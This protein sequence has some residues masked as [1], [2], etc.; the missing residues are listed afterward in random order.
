M[1]S[2][3]DFVCSS[4]PTTRTRTVHNGTKLCAAPVDVYSLRPSSLEHVTFTSYFRD[5]RLVA[6]KKPRSRQQGALP[7]A[8]PM[9]VAAAA[10]GAVGGGLAAAAA[11]TTAAATATASA[12][13]VGLAAAPVL[14]AAT[15]AAAAG[16]AVAGAAAWAATAVQHHE[17][18]GPVMRQAPPGADLVGETMDKHHHVYKLCEPRIVRFS[19]YNPAADPEGYFYTLLLRHVPFRKE[20]ELLSAANTSQTYFQECR[21]RGL[22]A[23]TSDLEVHLQR[24]GPVVQ[25]ARSSGH[26]PTVS[27]N[28]AGACTAAR[29]ALHPGPEARET[30][31]S[32]RAR[33]SCLHSSSATPLHLLI[34]WCCIWA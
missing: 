5:Y 16:A 26:M 32:S 30:P 13:A 12:A 10:V 18:D 19:D 22:V 17:Q 29:F 15:A 31:R 4:P 28:E 3:V 21:L 34:P 20:G 23:N 1:S 6:R 33:P 24:Y 2:G 11:T 25:H 7:Q 8:V 14:A 9:G 27:A